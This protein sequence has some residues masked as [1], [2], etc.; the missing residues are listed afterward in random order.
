MISVAMCT[1][2]GSKYLEEQLNSIIHQTRQP[3]EIV[4]CDDRSKDDSIEIAQR[5]LE[6]WNGIIRIVR[7]EKNL[8]FVKNF[9]KAISF[10]MEIL[11]F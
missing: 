3:D 2:N 6:N 4:I 9:E 1:Y 7:N 11:F 8:G 5:T 10:A